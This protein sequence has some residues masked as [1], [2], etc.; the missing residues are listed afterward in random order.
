MRLAGKFG[1]ITGAASGLGLETAKLLAARGAAVL[2][3]DVDVANGELAAANIRAS[4]GTALFQ[5]CDVSAEDDIISAIARVRH[6]WGRFNYIHNNAAI[7][8]RVALHEL[9]NDQWDRINTVNLKAV[10]WGIKHAVNAM[11]DS[12]ESG[13]I[14]NSASVLSLVGDAGLPAYTAA[15]HAVLGLTRAAGAAYAA[16]GIRCNCVCPG[17]METP[18]ITQAWEATGNA[19]NAKMRIASHYPQKRIGQAAEVAEMVAFLIS[20]ESSYVNASYMVVDGGLLSKA[21]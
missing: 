17:D 4:G 16:D 3:T 10:F 11:R 19:E 9:T 6:E 7:Q 21:Y 12:G 15:K 13:S 8:I 5:R 14:V 1:L 20:D 18:L 2:L